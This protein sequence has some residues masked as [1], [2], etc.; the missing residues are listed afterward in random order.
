MKVNKSSGLAGI[1]AGTSAISTV[2]SSG[3][4]LYYR[5][6]SISDLSAH[7]CFEEVAYL[8]IHGRLP[9]RSQLDLYKKL[10][11]LLRIPPDPVL[12]VVELIPKEAHPMAVLRT[13][14]SMLGALSNDLV[15][16]EEAGQCDLLLACMPSVMV[17]WHHFAHYG[18]RIDLKSDDK[19]LSSYFL[20]KLLGYMPKKQMC[21]M[22]DTSLI[23]YAEHDFNA[24]TFSARI[25]ASTR[26]DLF[27]AIVS[28][29]G[30][31]KGP[32][33]GGANE[34]ALRLLQMFATPK[35]A[36]SGIDAMLAKKQL[37]MGFGHR[38]Y[39]QEDPRSVII[40]QY[41]QQLAAQ[42]DTG[43][44]LYAVA[45]CIEKQMREK[46]NKYPNLDFYSAVV[47]HLCQI[48]TELFTPLFVFARISGWSAHILEQRQVG[49][50][51]RPLSAYIGPEHQEF[52]PIKVRK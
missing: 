18:V 44:S 50:L 28:A 40:K 26:S 23:L 19:S 29:I 15:I 31:L 34:E 24:S 49:K 21:D 22:L 51:I 14:C 32:L 39:K 13:A 42:S 46:I 4:G 9:N 20:T 45:E 33:H 2:E 5:G 35:D 47:Y 41:A 12:E 17:Y 48:P 27:S 52:I 37:I 36:V 38:V 3:S 43:R 30:T 7:C 1:I 10:L 16:K 8:L 6:Y 25:T 11:V